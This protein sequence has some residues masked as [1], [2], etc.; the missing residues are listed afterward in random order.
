[1]SSTYN[2]LSPIKVPLE[3][4]DLPQVLRENLERYNERA[5]GAYAQNTLDAWNSDLRSFWRICRDLGLQPFPA[6]N[7]VIEQVIAYMGE[8]ICKMKKNTEGE[9]AAVFVPRYRVATIRRYL[10]SVSKIHNVAGVYDPTR[11]WEADLALR[12]V[13]NEHGEEGFGQQS[14]AAPLNQ[15]DLEAGLKAMSNTPRSK[16]IRSLVSLAYDCLCRSEDL[17]RADV[18]DIREH[19]DGTGAFRI[20]KGKTDQ[21]GEGKVLFISRTTMAYLRAWISILPEQSKA[22]FPMVN[23]GQVSDTRIDY[24]FIYRAMKEVAR[25]AGIDDSKISTHSCRVGAAQDMLAAG[26][27]MAE[28]MNAGRW[29]SE[30]MPSRYTEYQQA[31]RSGMAKLCN[32]INR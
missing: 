30:R 2:A 26:M 18:V 11:S 23:D 9:P 3:D 29:T 19:G 21:E 17:I 1:M 27:T 12:S 4:P 14:Q 13:K 6:S 5:E 10:A 25:L 16:L 31:G 7:T 32:Q 28:I 8:I 22:L 20:R 15:A 24:M